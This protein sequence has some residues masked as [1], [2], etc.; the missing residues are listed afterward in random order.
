GGELVRVD[1]QLLGDDAEGATFL[2]DARAFERGIEAHDPNIGF[3]RLDLLEMT[4]EA[5][6]RICDRDDDTVGCGAG[7]LA[8]LEE[9]ERFADLVLEIEN[10]GA[11]PLLRG[12][13]GGVA[14]AA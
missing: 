2:P 13:R 10:E 5:R 12:A 6:R 9:R 3:E 11:A 1:P 14:E 7:G 8:A 4:G